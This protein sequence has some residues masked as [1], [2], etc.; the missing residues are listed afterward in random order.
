[1]WLLYP[2]HE[3]RGGV[4]GGGW[5]SIVLECLFSSIRMWMLD[6]YQKKRSVGAIVLECVFASLSMWLPV[7]YVLYF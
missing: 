5:G 3:Q 7:L 1:M 6:P 4:G 2:Y